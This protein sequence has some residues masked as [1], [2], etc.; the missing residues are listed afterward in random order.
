MADI[1]SNGAIGNIQSDVGLGGV[2]DTTNYANERYGPDLDT[3]KLRRK[4]NF[5]DRVSELSLS[6]DPF[7][8]FASK[9]AKSPTDD[10]AFKYTEKRGSWH[11]RYAYV[12]GWLDNSSASNDGGVAGDADLVA[13]NDGGAPDAM[14]LGDTIKVYMGTDYESSGNIQNVYGQANNA[15]AVGAAGT[16]PSFFFEGQLVKIP[17]SSTDGG[18][19]VTDYMVIKVESAD[20]ATVD[21]REASLIVGKVTKLV[22]AGGGSNYLAGWASD[23][24]LVTAY[25]QSISGTLEGARS[26]VVGT[27]FG[28]GTGYP[29][30][31]KDQ[32]YATGYGLTQI[33]KTAMAMTN[34]ARATSLKYESNEWSRIWREKLIEHK[35]DI[36]QSLLFGSQYVDG[37][38]VQYTEGAVDFI[39]N[40]GNKFSLN[41][42]TKTADD[43][44]DD[45][46]SYLD[47]R[48]N[49]STGTVFFVNTEVFN[50]MHKLGGYFKN[51]LEI[52]ANMRADFAMSGKKKVLGVD[53]TT[54]S[55]PYGDMNVARNIH[56][57]GTPVKMLGINMNYAKYR[58][59][60]GNGINRDTSVYVGVQT[61]ENSGIDRRVDMIL[62]EAGMEWSMPECHAIWTA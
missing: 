1:F 59:L 52:S 31:W 43:F 54:F 37:D 46:S 32:P 34:T 14:S 55:T 11:K 20:D 48:Y 17:M 38:G 4:F 2:A 42:A 10:P 16:R 27:A 18:G 5:G 15:I 7:F 12:T 39:T 50:W 26:F 30:T 61:L 3:G 44:L 60:V 8:R 28:E 41:T 53:I 47:P 9:V 21:G 29:E 6:Q 62:T 57:D 35:Y 23:E 40:N 33:W 25:N 22:K 51:N 49:N 36:E 58:P 13:F 19:S 45:M 56:L 24:P